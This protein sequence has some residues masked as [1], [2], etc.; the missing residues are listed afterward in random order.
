MFQF[1]TFV[2]VKMKRDKMK[3]VWGNK[4]MKS[5]TDS[6][7]E[8]I[9][10]TRQAREAAKKKHAETAASIGVD[11]PTYTNYESRRPMPQKYIAK[12][13]QYTGVREKWLLTGEGPMVN[14]DDWNH[15]M[16]ELDEEHRKVMQEQYEFL[17]AKSRKKKL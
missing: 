9:S 3:P 11:R 10:R 5:L 8:Y 13:C 14:L 4:S 7:R 17:L 15:K 16:S 6:Q 2:N 12:F 1:E